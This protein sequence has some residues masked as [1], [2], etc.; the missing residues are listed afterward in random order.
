MYPENDHFTSNLAVQSSK[1]RYYLEVEKFAEEIH[2]KWRTK[3][4]NINEKGT[5][6]LKQLLDGTLFNINVPYE[7]LHPERKEENHHSAESALKILYMY[8]SIY[9]WNKDMAAEEF[10]ISWLKRNKATLDISTC[11]PYTN[12][13]ESIKTG[14]S[15]S[16]QF[17]K[18]ISSLNTQTIK[19]AAEDL[20]SKWRE[21]HQKTSPGQ[22]RIKKNDSDDTEGDI[23]VPFD[24]LHPDWQRENLLAA[25]AA[26]VSCELFSDDEIAAYYCHEQWMIRNRKDD[27]NAHQHVS[28][29]DLNRD[30]QL[31][32]LVQ[33]TAMRERIH[34][35]DEIVE[36]LAEKLH[37]KWRDKY[38]P[39]REGKPRIKAN[40]D[41]TTGDIN[42]PFKELHADWKKENLRAAYA[43]KRAC[44]THPMNNDAAAEFCHIE[45]MK[46]N[47]KESWN[48]AQHVPYAELS[49]EEKQKDMD[50]VEIMREILK[51]N[52]CKSLHDIDCINKNDLVAL[53]NL[54][55]CV[56]ESKLERFEA[57]VD[58]A[59]DL[60][61][62]YDP[63]N[64]NQMTVLHYAI[65]MPVK[66]IETQIQVIDSLLNRGA[67][68]DMKAA[69]G[70]TPLILA[71]Y[72]GKVELVKVLLNHPHKKPDLN[73]KDSDGWTALM[74]ASFLCHTDIVRL[75]L[76]EGADP[77]ISTD[78]D[79]WTAI[80]LAT[81]RNNNDIVKLLVSKIAI[82]SLKR[83]DEN[84]FTLLHHAVDLAIE[85]SEKTTTLLTLS[86]KLDALKDAR[87]KNDMAPI[88]IAA[89]KGFLS[90]V[91]LL[92]LLKVDIEA[93]TRPAL[94]NYK[95]A[96]PLYLAAIHNHHEVVKYLLSVGAKFKTNIEVLTLYGDSNV[97]RE[98]RNSAVVV[99]SRT[100][101]VSPSLHEDSKLSNPFKEAAFRGHLEVLKVFCNHPTS[102]IDKSQ[103]SMLPHEFKSIEYLSGLR[104]K[105]EHLLQLVS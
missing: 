38:D 71:S 54:I 60:I 30:E 80:I 20:H 79:G 11:V 105:N 56:C 13:A 22:K 94:A 19:S 70:F 64:N 87:N 58:T 69:N 7:K 89:A 14:N 72:L 68:I 65:R 1:T 17:I 103:K 39:K 5:E 23:N 92:F 84:N 36:S 86:E 61:N 93:S 63:F 75:L 9:P 77:T 62:K 35:D 78:T 55:E 104:V 24:L 49:A 66:K 81:R 67:D 15:E 90:H 2:E 34:F 32:D 100:F 95:N 91:K 42:Q 88:H 43:A 53:K 99:S 48:A 73:R 57:Y 31:K 3:F 41:G 6:R 98:R 51:Y 27:Y 76:S 96:T 12:L 29:F 102:I 83:T 50:Q 40:S 21:E 47:P 33:V 28:Y 74:W 97:G 25:F 10:H 37:E 85:D 18:E 52:S 59:R 101:P 8:P 26:K 45:W 46:R 82:D 44:Q 16:I 4:E